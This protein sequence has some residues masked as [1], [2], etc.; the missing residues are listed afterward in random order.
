MEN[1]MIKHLLSIAVIGSA[2]FICQS[3]TAQQFVTRTAEV[4]LL[5]TTPI[6]DIEGLN[7]QSSMILDAS[8][9]DIAVQVPI[10][11]FHFEKALLEEHF[12]ENY[13]E[14]DKFPKATFRGSVAGWTVMPLEGETMNVL[15]TGTF[16]VHGVDVT[17]DFEGQIRLESGR[18][19]VDC[20][21]EVRPED[22]GIEIPGVV[23]KQIAAIITIDVSA[24]LS[25]R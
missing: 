20:T 11:G 12:N 17:R 9:G 14:S 7:K 15:V 10:L 16:T 6:E 4:H 25:A 2:G 24:Q 21:F 1:S 22:H 23:R 5:S 19:I 3:L 8:N 18:L 13:M